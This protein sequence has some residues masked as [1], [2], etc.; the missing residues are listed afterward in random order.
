MMSDITTSK[1][2]PELLNIKFKDEFVEKYKLILDDEIERFLYFH[3]LPIERSIRV[4][5][6]KI[7]TEK[8][9]RRLSAKGWK[10]EQM[11]WYRDGLWV[12]SPKYTLGKAIE[13]RLGYF[14]MQGPASMIPPLILNP[15][16]NDI[17]L[18]ISAAPGSKTTQMAAMMNNKGIIIANDIDFSRLNALRSNL[19]RCGVVN[20]IVTKID[21][22]RF[23]KLPNKYDKVL[24]DAPC[25]GDGTI[26][27]RPHIA[28]QWNQKVIL[29]L[30]RLQTSLLI[31]A[32]DS[33]KDGGTLV[34]ST[35]TLNPEEDEMVV[36]HLLE[37]R[38]SAKLLPVSL[39]GLK[40]R[41]GL[42]EFKD[43]RFDSDLKKTARI[44]PQDNNT[45]GF[46][47]AKVVKR[48]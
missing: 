8:L 13:H 21:G 33:L 39:E 26:R 9:I 14:Y 37:K 41:P 44:Y 42:V 36:Q 31:S 20:V 40:I 10:I 5:T 15:R 19:Q 24:L 27:I 32:F 28:V 17:V 18:D 12:Y 16:E 25:S 1:D 30:S 29:G 2:E 35:C 38:P 23:G 7:S 22:R 46:Y 47:I 4:N 34:Y 6:I 45:E 11:K 48:E 3:R 43:L